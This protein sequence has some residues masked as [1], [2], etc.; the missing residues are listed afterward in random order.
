MPHW[1]PSCTSFLNTKDSLDISW[2]DIINYPLF[3]DA[4]TAIYPQAAAQYHT[5]LKAKRGIAMLN[6]D[7]F[8]YLRK[9]TRCNKFI[10]CSNDFCQILKCFR[11]FKIS[12]TPFIWPK[13]SFKHSVAQSHCSGKER[14]RWS[15]SPLWSHQWCSFLII[16][17]AD[18]A[19]VR[20]V[21]ILHSC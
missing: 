16:F 1:S 5:R 13:S 2:S 7:K 11:S 3:A 18:D 14:G 6:V 21:C 9:Q 8:L 17:H 15:W 20:Y 19:K 4:D 12:D 10:P